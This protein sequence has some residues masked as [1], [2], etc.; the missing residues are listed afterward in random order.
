M[1]SPAQL[2]VE[3]TARCKN[4]SIFNKKNADS[5]QF[6]ERSDLVLYVDTK[7]DVVAETLQICIG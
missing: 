7:H 2:G 4:H 6:L 1:C 5:H 3:W